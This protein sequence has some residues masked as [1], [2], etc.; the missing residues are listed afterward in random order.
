MKGSMQEAK[1]SVFRIHTM[2][3]ELLIDD[4]NCTVMLD[5][6]FVTHYSFRS[7]GL[8]WFHPQTFVAKCDLFVLCSDAVRNERCAIDKKKRQRKLVVLDYNDIKEFSQG[9]S[10]ATELTKK[11][12]AAWSKDRHLL[13]HNLFSTPESF[14]T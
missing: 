10:A 7:Y 6:V 11:T 13:P 8:C 14:M 12:F 2:V 4:L 3:A 9:A 1:H 5:C